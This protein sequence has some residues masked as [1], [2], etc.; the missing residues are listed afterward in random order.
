MTDLVIFMGALG[1]FLLILV[2]AYAACEAVLR[3]VDRWPR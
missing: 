1:A 3:I 2:G